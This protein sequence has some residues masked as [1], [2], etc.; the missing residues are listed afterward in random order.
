VIANNIF[1]WFTRSSLPSSARNALVLCPML[2][3]LSG[4]A[5]HKQ[6]RI[7]AQPVKRGFQAPVEP[8]RIGTKEKGEASWYGEP[9][10]GRRAASGEIFD[11]EQLTAAHRTLP[12]QTWVEVT[13]LDNGKHV[14]VRII[15]R[16]PFVDGRI[17][18]LSRGAAREIDLLRTGVAKV[19]LRVI[20]APKLLSQVAAPVTPSQEPSDLNPIPSG[21]N[22]APS[23]PTPAG[24][25]VVQ[26][27]A[28]SSRERAEALV[29]S[30]LILG[31]ARLVP[32]DAVPPL[33]RV[34]VGNNLT[35]DLARK[36]ADEVKAITGQ[37]VIVRGR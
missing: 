28:F 30:L 36:L 22:P 34:W 16:G 14:D 11:M 27:G 7:P 19:E 37:S 2:I 17:I 6:A 8:A 29:S 9:Y 4:C 18:D 1:A 15:D 21:P 26:A 13:N 5:K 35:M 10:N 32:T 33:W 31:E 20:E 23:R 25:F 3:A 12:F 24:E